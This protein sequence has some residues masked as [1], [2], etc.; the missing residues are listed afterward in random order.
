MNFVAIYVLIAAV[1]AAAV[2]E[3]LW[4]Y[5]PAW[6][7]SF[8]SGGGGGG[9]YDVKPALYIPIKPSSSH[10]IEGFSLATNA[11]ST[12]AAGGSGGSAWD[13]VSP[14]T[15]SIWSPLVSAQNRAQTNGGS[16]G[17]LSSS[18]GYLQLTPTQIQF[19]QS[20]GGNSLDHLP[21][22]GDIDT[23]FPGGSGS[24]PNSSVQYS[25]L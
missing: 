5:Y 19:L 13:F 25:T 6:F 16:S 4:Y 3:L 22:K 20:R 7:S 12:S 21:T 8:G 1:A 23:A 24:T 14:P 15:L 18:A 11:S 10:S 17:G 9:M 2:V